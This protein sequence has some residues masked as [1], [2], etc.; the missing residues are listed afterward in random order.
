MIGASELDQERHLSLIEHTDW[1]LDMQLRPVLT[2]TAFV[3]TGLVAT[4]GLVIT[5]STAAADM[6]FNSAERGCDGSDP[7][8]LFCDDFEAGSWYIKNCDQANT[9]GGLLQTRGWCGSIFSN[10][11][12][13]AGAAVCSGAG[14]AGTNCA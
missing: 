5:S 8:V 6:Y 3:I 13:P 9:S 1:R 12:T 11:I 14:A 2:L 4:L 7:N 10:L